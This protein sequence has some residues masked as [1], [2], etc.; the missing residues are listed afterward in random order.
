M[1]EAAGVLI[2]LSKKIDAHVD[3]VWGIV[4]TPEGFGAWM[5]GTVSF[6]PDAGS[7]FEANFPQFQMVIRGEVREFDATA[8][9]LVLT[10]GVAQGPQ[11]ETFPAG[12]SL[13]ELTLTPENGGTD[14]RVHHSQLPTEEG[15]EGHE[16]G[17]RFH[18]SRLSLQAN[19]QDLTN[20]LGRSV[21]AWFAAWNETDAD[22]RDAL[23]ISCCS[24]DVA[25]RD[26]YA[27]ATGRQLLSMHIGSTQMFMPG[28]S[29]AAAGPAIVCRGE[30]LVPWKG[31]GPNGL[32]V[33]GTNHIAAH[34]DGTITR[35]TGF[36]SAG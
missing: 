11:T 8:H 36:Y 31:T 20:N 35:V 13:L 12:S 5:G 25:F 6:S 3:T 30:A 17:W 2:D 10:W 18:L 14:A 29:I 21:D 23:L 7:P 26:E 16:A 32:E 33:T 15:A 4:S 1:T 24:E 34:P 22:A 27:D 28:F 9:R 19:R